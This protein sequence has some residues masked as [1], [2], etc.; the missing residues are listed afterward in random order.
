M[1][2]IVVFLSRELVGPE[3]A[4]SPVEAKKKHLGSS[5]GDVVSVMNGLARNEERLAQRLLEQ[6][7]IISPNLMGKN[8][9]KQSKESGR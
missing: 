8:G 7:A 3:V 2:L 4:V 6:V 9:V 5:I 1:N